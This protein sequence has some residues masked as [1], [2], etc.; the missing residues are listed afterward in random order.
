M[1]NIAFIILLIFLSTA[2]A[3]SQQNRAKLEQDKKKVE[4]E[5]EYTNKLLEQTR[6]TRQNSLNEVVILNKKIGKREQL[7]NTINS[8]VRLVENQM[9]LAQ[10]SIDLLV[11]DLQN[12][13]DEYA[14]MIYYAYKNKNL[15]DRLIFILAAEDFNQAYQRMKYFEHYNEYR[16]QQALLIQV[17]QKRLEIKMEDL[18]AIRN[19]KNNLLTSE[20]RQKQQLTIEREEK[21]KSVQTLSK[22]EKELQK[23]LKE[24]EAAARKLQQAIQDIIAEEI[25]LANERANKPGAATEKAGLFSLTPE[26]R[27]LS[28]NFLSNQGSLPWPLEQGIISSTFGEHPHPVLK[29]VKTRNNGIDMLTEPG[30]EA[31]SIFSGVVT[32]VMNVPNN[33]NVIII[34]HGEFLTVYSN[35]DDVY[36]RVGEKVTIKQ[37]IGKVFTNKTDSKTELHF[38]IW[39]SK[40]LL[41]PEE[42]LAH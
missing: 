37:K 12:L 24:K 39:Q 41:D 27:I 23:T 14:K 36:V 11:K 18:A 6:Q 13:K 10:D 31:R 30:A 32:R 29:N 33:N 19:Q 3:W 17:K 25:R 7:I 9:A 35:L 16:K 20:E 34:R 28:D 15:Y 22:K 38:E 4:E 1:R 2:A 5:I 42:W 21:N 8:E 26:E 40:T